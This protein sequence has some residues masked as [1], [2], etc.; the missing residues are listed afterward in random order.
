MVDRIEKDVG[1]FKRILRGKVRENLRRYISQGEMIGKQGKDLVSIPIPQIDIP[2]FKLDGN[3]QGGVGSG[4]G[5]PGDPMG[6]DQGEGSGAGEAGNNP[7][8]HPMEVELTFDELV[9]IMAEELELPNIEPKGDESVQSMKG[10]YRGIAPAGPNSLRHFKRTYK[11]ALKRQISSKE[12]NPLDPV[13]VPIRRDQRYRFREMTPEPVTNAVIILMMDVSG[14]MEEEQKEIVRITSFWIDTWLR[15]HYKGLH[16]RYIIHDTVAQEVDKDTFFRVRE[17]GGTVISSAYKLCA[18][19]IEEH[20]PS[21]QW[22]IYPFHFSDGD[23]WSERDNE[24][25]IKIIRDQLIP[26]SN[27]FCYGQVESRYGSGKFLKE[28]EKHFKDNE[29]LSM[30]KIENKDAIVKGIK[31]FLGKG[32]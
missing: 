3:K 1:R 18:K 5:E 10:R 14:S 26:A 12:Y 27:L 4:D 9:E 30:V 19:I 25:C 29:R 11:E 23:N 7:G 15:A 16:T 28:L 21:D 6:G 24:E 20:Y 32:K 22:N 13:I 31:T 17:S 2:H 8:E